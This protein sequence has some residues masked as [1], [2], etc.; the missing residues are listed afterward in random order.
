MFREEKEIY[1]FRDF[2]HDV[3]NMQSNR[4]WSH[5]KDHFELTQLVSE[6]NSTGSST[7]TDH[8]Y[9]KLPKNVN[10]INMSKMGLSF[11]IILARK[12]Q[13]LTPKANHSTKSYRSFKDFDKKYQ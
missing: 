4:T 2:S 12:R 7:L 6:A 1:L 10:T 5:Y 8:I 9:D 3:L 13:R 11:P